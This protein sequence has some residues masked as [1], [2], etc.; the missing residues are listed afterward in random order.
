MHP[1]P[2]IINTIFFF[3]NTVNYVFLVDYYTKQQS[4]FNLMKLQK[5]KQYFSKEQTKFNKIINF[6]LKSLIYR[7]KVL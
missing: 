3:F 2:I 7:L 6:F 5:S 1:K 4:G